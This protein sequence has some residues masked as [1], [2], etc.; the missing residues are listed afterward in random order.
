MGCQMKGRHKPN[1]GHYCTAH[2]CPNNYSVDD[3]KHP[4][5]D[6]RTNPT[7]PSPELYTTNLAKVVAS[8]DQGEY[9]RNRKSTGISKP[10][11]LSGLQPKLSLA[12]PKCFTVDLMHLLILNLVNLLIFL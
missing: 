1:S 9:E 4:D 8:R 5:Y 11:I 2:L 10:S 3:C 6:F 12:I 7:A